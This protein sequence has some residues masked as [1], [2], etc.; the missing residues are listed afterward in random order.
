M[1]FVTVVCDKCNRKY[2]RP[3]PFTT[4]DYSS[5]DMKIEI[6]QAGW[7]VVQTNP[8]PYKHF[9]RQCADKM[10]FKRPNEDT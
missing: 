10:G 1:L 7:V 5:G 9:C 8:R 3:H 4:G 6:Q 2:E